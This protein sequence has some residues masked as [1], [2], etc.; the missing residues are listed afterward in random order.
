MKK[1]ECPVCLN[2]VFDFKDFPGSYDICPFCGWEDDDTQYINPEFEG[3]ANDVSLKLARENY[4][5]YGCSDP[6]KE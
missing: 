5:I 1:I 4:K 3:G 6:L 2:K